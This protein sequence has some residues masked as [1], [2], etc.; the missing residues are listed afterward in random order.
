[1]RKLILFP[2][3]LLLFACSQQE[4][5]IIN[6]SPSKKTNTD[7]TAIGYQSPYANF[8]LHNSEI[9]YKFVNGTDLTLKVIA[10]FG[11]AFYDGKDDLKHNVPNGDIFNYSGVNY[12]TLSTNNKEYGNYIEAEEITMPPHYGFNSLS[13]VLVPISP[14]AITPNNPNGFHF[15]FTNNTT[16]DE[17]V[18]ISKYGKL[19]F[20]KF[21]AFDSTTPVPTSKSIIKTFFPEGLYTSSTNTLPNGWKTINKDNFFHEELV[22]NTQ[23]REICI[24]TQEGSQYK[25][26]Y[27][28]NYQNKNYKVYTE[29]DNDR[30]II[31]LIEI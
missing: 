7:D 24:T 16:I 11:L 4:D 1:M 10:N 6:D 14:T 18:I 28:F 29:L 27:K 13:S 20:I 9:S 31:F 12:P 5:T 8:H 19:H 2:L 21:E 30:V 15:N 23:S 22:Y 26:S 17:S 3:S 25:T